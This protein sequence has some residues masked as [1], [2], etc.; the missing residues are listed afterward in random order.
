[1][2]ASLLS[3]RDAM[4]ASTFFDVAGGGARGAAGYRVVFDHSLLQE[5]SAGRNLITVF[6]TVNSLYQIFFAARARPGRCARPRPIDIDAPTRERKRAR[7]YSQP[8]HTSNGAACSDFL[9]ARTHARP[10]IA[11]PRRMHA[12]QRVEHFDGVDASSHALM[13]WR[14]AQARLRKSARTFS[15]IADRA[16]V[17]FALHAFRKRRTRDVSAAGSDASKQA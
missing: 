16:R 12:R 9:D 1:M 10:T 17:A 7:K 2:D 3:A 13:P 14:V 5:T 6:S 8:L 4:P 15:R 11:R